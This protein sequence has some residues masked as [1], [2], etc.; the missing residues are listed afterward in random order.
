MAAMAQAQAEVTKE[1]QRAGIAHARAN[2]NGIKYRGRKPTFTSEQFWAV[3]ELL[4]QGLAV[5]VIARTTGV[6][7][8]S[9]Y[10]IRANPERQLA[11]LAAWYAET[12]LQQS[13]QSS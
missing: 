9:I 8:Q 5:S 1:A 4:D 10:R 13:R 11:A 2:D 7:R 12:N 3:R 6:S